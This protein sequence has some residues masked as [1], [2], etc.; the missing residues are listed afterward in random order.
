MGKI[1]INQSGMP[2]WLRGSEMGEMIFIHDWK[3][4]GLDP[5]DAWP[6]HLQ[7][8]VNIVL[9]LPSAAILLWGPDLIQLYNDRFRDL[10]G[11]KHPKGLGQAVSECWPE[12]WDFVRPVCEAVMQRGE[13]LTFDEQRLILNRNGG[14]EESFFKL[15]YSPIPGGMPSETGSMLRPGGV[16]VTVTETTELVRA[17]EKEAER[18]Q[19]KETLQ[20][21]RIR[22]LEEAFRAAPSFLHVLRGPEFIF[23]FANDAYYQLVG[24]RELIGLP[25]FEAIPESAQGG[26]QERLLQ[27]MATGKPFMGFELPMTLARA[28]G[29]SPEE[30]FIDLV[31]LPL[32]DEDGICQRVLGHGID[33]TAHVQKRRKAEEALRESEERFRQALEIDTVG[34]IFF[35]GQGEITELNDAFLKMSGFSREDSRAGLLPWQGRTQPEWREI[36]LR[37]AGEFEATGRIIPYE[38]E[39]L[40]KDGSRWWALFSAKQLA[41]KEGVGYVIDIT[42]RK[43]AERSALESEARFRAMSEASPALTWQ[44]DQEGNVVYLNQRYLDMV[45]MTSEE[46]MPAGWRSILHPDDAPAYVAAFEQALR[47][48]SHFRHRVRI[49]T[50]K[51]EWHWLKSYA[52]P[53]YTTAGE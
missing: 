40:R 50:A 32:F 3:E 15:T 47:D 24:H 17:R 21:N 20:A 52:M 51:G 8:A 16:L 43:H 37:T 28:P 14:P 6:A 1:S 19:L 45:G 38:H 18:I 49:R 5:V 13:S 41:A 26:Y 25:A 12:A 10:M 7:L 46:L 36:F 42:K 53:W 35:N 39:F 29:Q 22:L 23:E 4:S 9:L 30:H 27:V 48:R 2:G 31:Y 11:G 34:I 33:V 44:V